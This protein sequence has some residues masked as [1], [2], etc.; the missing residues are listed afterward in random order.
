[1]FSYLFTRK[2]IG[3]IGRE[4]VDSCN[5]MKCNT[6]NGTTRSA[7]EC[8]SLMQYKKRCQ[9]WHQ[10]KNWSEYH[11]YTNK[12][13]MRLPFAFRDI[14]R[15]IVITWINYHAVFSSPKYNRVL[16][17]S[18]RNIVGNSDLLLVI[19]HRF[20]YEVQRI[21]DLVTWLIE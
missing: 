12:D 7:F 10:V 18:Y 17:T 1:M 8:H 11:T 3:Q 13:I 20:L 19:N 2:C 4:C 15:E 9:L 16:S 5:R 21:S 14:E 6:M